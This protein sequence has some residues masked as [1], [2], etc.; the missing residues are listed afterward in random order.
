MCWE[1]KDKFAERCEEREAISRKSNQISWCW[2]AKF[3]WTFQEC[4]FRG[5]WWGVWEEEGEE[6]EDTWWWNEEV[7]GRKFQGRKTHTRQCVWILLRRIRGGMKAWIMKQRKQ[8][9]KQWER[10]QKNNNWIKKLPKFDV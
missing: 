3:V 1:K 10:R 7:R 4:G 8:L 6:K 5:M 2:S 9:H